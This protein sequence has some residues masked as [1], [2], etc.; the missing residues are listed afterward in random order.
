MVEGVAQGDH[1]PEQHK[2]NSKL[3][4]GGGGGGKNSDKAWQQAYL[5][6]K[7]GILWL[8]SILLSL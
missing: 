3:H 2:H 8:H 5:S 1:H 4:L 6:M 7:Y